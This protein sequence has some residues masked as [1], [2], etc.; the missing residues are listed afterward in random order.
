MIFLIPKIETAA[1]IG[2][3]TKKEILAAS[4]RL[5]SNILAAVIAIPDLLTPGINEKICKI[6]IKKTDFKLK[7][8]SIFFFNLNL[9]L[10]KSNIQNTSVVQ[11]IVFI[12]LIFSIKFVSTRK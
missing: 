10:I 6:P 9:S 4:T 5:Y 3:D 7:L 2:I 8:F 1:S 12:F 11:A